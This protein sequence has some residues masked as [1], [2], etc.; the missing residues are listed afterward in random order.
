MARRRPPL[1]TPQNAAGWLITYADLCILLLSFFV[2]LVSM[3][4]IDKT[5]QKQAMRSVD[6]SFGSPAS[7]VSKASEAKPAV[8]VSANRKDRNSPTEEELVILRAMCTTHGLDPG[9]VGMEKGKIIIRLERKRLLRQGT[10]EIEPGIRPYL[11]QLAAYLKKSGRPIELRGHTDAGEEAGQ[12]SWAKRSWI[13]SL[14]RAQAA[15]AFFKANGMDVSR[16]T[17]HGFAHYRP[18]TDAAG[19]PWAGETNQRVEVILP[20]GKKAAESRLVHN[21][22]ENRPYADYKRFFSDRFPARLENGR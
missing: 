21:R 8:N 22:G 20:P 3:S 17:V 19:K 15:A 12:S 18:V 13:L 14:Q 10:L 16:M 4:T 2:L 7:V 11:S 6:G 9:L 5:L 1:P